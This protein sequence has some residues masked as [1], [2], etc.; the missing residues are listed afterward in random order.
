MLPSG[1]FEILG[2]A[3]ASLRCFV[4]RAL[5]LIL[6]CGSKEQ[7]S[8]VGFTS[9]SFKKNKK[10]IEPPLHQVSFGSEPHCIASK[11]AACLSFHD[12]DLIKTNIKPAPSRNPKRSLKRACSSCSK[13][14]TDLHTSINCCGQPNASCSKVYYLQRQPIC[15]CIPLGFPILKRG[16][17]VSLFPKLSV[18]FVSASHPLSFLQGR[19]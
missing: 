16:G 11:I 6:G 9:F 1:F 15:P 19:Q 8:P 13:R 2:P 5:Q 10:K 7:V 17:K 3:T 14:S 12:G 18:F 4:L